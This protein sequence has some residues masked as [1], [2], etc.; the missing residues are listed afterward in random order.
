MSAAVGQ[1]GADLSEA[2]QSLQAECINALPFGSD[3]G[4]GLQHVGAQRF[5]EQIRKREQACPAQVLVRIIQPVLDELCV[6]APAHLPACRRFG[7]PVDGHCS[8]PV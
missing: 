3:E 2:L 6:L 7:S 5:R 8:G 1:C 4:N